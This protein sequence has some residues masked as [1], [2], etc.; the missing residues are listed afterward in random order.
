M[1]LAIKGGPCISNNSKHVN[2]SGEDTVKITFSKANHGIDMNEEYSPD[3][4]TKELEIN[5]YKEAI[6]KEPTKI[7][8][9]V[10]MEQWSI[11]SDH[12]KY[13]THGKSETFQKLSINSMN[14][15]QNR[16]LYK[17]A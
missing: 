15:R 1:P 7:I 12:I 3:E 4:T 14:Y 6:L 13:V 2:P 9:Q 5:S 10:P 11:L 16:D 17:Y 8:D